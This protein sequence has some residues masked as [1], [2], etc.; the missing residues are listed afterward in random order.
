M[1]VAR[2]FSLPD[3][4]LLGVVRCAVPKACLCGLS[5]MVV[6]HVYTQ[7]TWRVYTFMRVSFK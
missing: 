6:T 7:G 1:P 4:H 3:I 2:L 5:F